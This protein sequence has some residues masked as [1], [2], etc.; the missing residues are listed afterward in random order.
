[1]KRLC[2]FKIGLIFCLEALS[3]VQFIFIKYP[4]GEIEIGGLSKEMLF[5]GIDS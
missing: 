2:L 3:R 1:M 5:M 4:F